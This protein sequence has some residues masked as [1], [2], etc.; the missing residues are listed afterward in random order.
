MRIQKALEEGTADNLNYQ[1]IGLVM[2]NLIFNKGSHLVSVFKDYMIVDYVEEFLK[3][4]YK[5]KSLFMIEN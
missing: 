2:H 1:Y 4:F 3:R 5:L